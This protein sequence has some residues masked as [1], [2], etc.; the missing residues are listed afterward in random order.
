LT[1]PVGH[2]D[3]KEDVLRRLLDCAKQRVKIRKVYVDRGFFTIECIR[4]F[5]S[6]GLKFLIPATKTSRVKTAMKVMPAPSVIKDFRM[7]SARFNLVII[8]DEKGKK[9]SFATNEDYDEN[10]LGLSQRLLA[11]YGKRWGIET[12]YRVKKGFRPQTTSKNY[13]IRLFYFLLSCLLYNLWIIAD[14]LT[15]IFIVG[16]KKAKRLITAYFFGK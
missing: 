2:F 9:L 10:D 3:K 1:L 7:G 13:L 6:V 4:V 5:N 11:L 14:I 12:S 16:R 8:A 15:C